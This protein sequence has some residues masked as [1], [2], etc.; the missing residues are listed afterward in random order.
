MGLAYALSG[1][2]DIEVVG[3]AGTCAEAR[4]VVADRRPMVVTV[5]AWLPDGDGIA[6]A[7]GL[8]QRYPTL[9][10]VVLADADDD[11][12]F[13]TMQAGLSAFVAK[14]AA[15]DQIVA[16]VRHATVA[17]DTFTAPGLADAMGRRSGRPGVLSR[18]EL[19]VL[20]L[21]RDGLSMPKTA[22]ALRVSDST[23]KTYV[24][25]IYDKL[26]VSNRSQALMAAINRGLLRAA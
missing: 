12:L 19:E 26:G 23:V 4:K 14:S 21:L 8:R 15:A 2:P 16:A 10:V 17:A 6:L 1:Y 25:R 22:V 9:G 20:E 11:L 7:T 5:D 24:A 18:R 3:E 13:R